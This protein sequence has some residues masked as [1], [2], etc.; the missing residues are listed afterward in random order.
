[1]ILIFLLVKYI[2]TYEAEDSENVVS[3]DQQISSETCPLVDEKKVKLPYGTNEEDEESRFGS[4]EDLYNG[5]I[6]AIC[7]GAPRSCFYVPCGHCATCYACA[8][9][10]IT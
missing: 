3:V 8:Q 2:G 4:S 10:Y 1:M 7:Y 5:T 6:C 9:R